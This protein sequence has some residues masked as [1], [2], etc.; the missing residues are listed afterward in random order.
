[1]A[2]V[3]QI[4]GGL[5]LAVIVLLLILFLGLKLFQRQIG[6]K[7][8]SWAGD[9]KYTYVPP[10]LHL[11][12]AK[13]LE[14]QD[15]NK[16]QGLSAAMVAL[17]FRDAGGYVPAELDYLRIRGFAHETEQVYGIVYEHDQGGVWIDFVTQYAD[18]RGMTH[19]TA[20]QGQL[21][22][23]MPGK[24]KAYDPEAE[25]EALYRRH[26]Q[27]RPADAPLPATAAGFRD[28]LEQ[29]YAESMDWR[30]AR[31]GATEEE[32][33]RQARAEGKELTREELTQ[34]R[35]MQV[36]QAVSNLDVV[37]AEQFLKETTL[38]AA[39]WQEREGR[40]IYIFDLLTPEMVAE[41][42]YGAVDP[43][44]EE[45]SVP[46][47]LVGLPARRMFLGLNARLPAAQRMEKAGTASRPVETDVWVGPVVEEDEDD[48]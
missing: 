28:A 20:P 30:N 33:L 12:H 26:L 43:E 24:S 11:Q 25:P 47:D 7:L 39:E 31:G 34:L 44:A 15:G 19:T 4:L 8:A 9:L 13:N 1:M 23:S 21:L 41:R 16:V 17:G 36:S 27:E 40:L 46:E 3:L 48:E 35:E 14:W 18:G 38:S 10:R 29:A 2:L 22:D 45:P 42:F 32:L 5:F 37:V 6:R